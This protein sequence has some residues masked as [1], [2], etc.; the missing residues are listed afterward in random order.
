MVLSLKEVC[1]AGR[2]MF[3]L[4]KAYTHRA[5]KSF[6]F[7]QV[8]SSSIIYDMLAVTFE[9]LQSVSLLNCNV[10]NAVYKKISFF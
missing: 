6:L 7:E 8:G 5:V 1:Q 10:D 4:A 2:L 3:V 9:N